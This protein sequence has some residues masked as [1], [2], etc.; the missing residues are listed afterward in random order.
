MKSIHILREKIGVSQRQLAQ[1][2]GLSF[3]TIQLL[4]S[5]K[6]DPQLSTLMAVA[7]AFGY[8]PH[9]ID[10]CMETVFAL[11]PESVAIISEH[12]RLKKEDWRI[13][14]FNFVDAFRAQRSAE[15]I[16]APPAGDIPA[17]IAALLA[18][19]VEALC[20]ELD[21]TPPVWCAAIPAL[22]TPWFVSGIENLKVMALLES[23]VWF[24]Q[25]N[26]FVLK[27]FLER[28]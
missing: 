2:A 6:H 20:G 12:L 28:K 27:N 3:R 22:P 5:E 11:P 13:P 14:F 10:R 9:L 15:Y 17:H 25:R 18:S 26:I 16:T 1:N 21:L 23:P 8:P 4:E 19:T 7:T 24:R